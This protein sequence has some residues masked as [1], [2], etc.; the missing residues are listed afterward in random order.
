[1]AQSILSHTLA[2]GLVLVA[3]VMDWLESAALTLLVPGGSAMDP[4][5]RGG[6]SVFTCEMALRGAG[7]RDS[8]AFVTALDNLGV[9]RAEGVAEPH[10][11]FSG[12]TLASNLHSALA[13]YADAV[14]RPRL[15]ESEFEPVRQVMLQELMAIEDDP[16]HKVMVELRR[17]H[18]PHPWG[19]PT[20]GTVEGLTAIASRDVARHVQRAYRPNGAILGVAGRIDWPA[21]K[22][23]V[24]SLFGDWPAVEVP[25]LSAGAHVAKREH[26]AHD[27]NQTQIGIAYDS[28]PYS[29]PLYFQAWGAVGALSG[30]MSSRLFT[31]VREKRGLCYSVYAAYHTL[32]DRGSVLCYAGTS[33]ERAQETLNVVLAELER[34]ALGIEAHE[35]DRLKARIKSALVMQQESSASRS[36]AVARDWYYLGRVRPL[37]EIV[38][39]VDALSCESINAYLDDNPPRD[40]TIVT[41]GPQPLEVPLGVS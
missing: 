29:H 11:S 40:F 38:S 36:S 2:N 41:L 26:L 30:G 20:H 10:T 17:R 24:E 18:Y 6:L 12:A 22:D 35:I 5:E 27:T 13:L 37:E 9:E 33:A 14:R 19:Q 1:M 7:A 34:L 8:R 3:E 15:P 25:P 16:A 4:A 39:I 32:R 23:Q 31:E 21:L 28:V